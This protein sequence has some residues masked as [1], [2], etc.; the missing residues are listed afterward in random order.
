MLANGTVVTCSRTE[1]PDL[2]GAAQVSLGL[3]GVV[4][5]VTLRVA[6]A[7]DLRL[8]RTHN[9]IAAEKLVREL[10]RMEVK[11]QST[12]FAWALEPYG[13]GA[14]G[15]GGE[16]GASYVVAA[17]SGK[18]LRACG[19]LPS[20]RVVDRNVRCV[21]RAHRALASHQLFERNKY[22]GAA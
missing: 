6:P 3:L 18:P 1:H 15:A 19:A 5:A 22:V 13:G 21:D 2:F 8:E 16:A 20:E 4:Y 14:A 10:G 9:I 11:H 17:I 7:A 12:R